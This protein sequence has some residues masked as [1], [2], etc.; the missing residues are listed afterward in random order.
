MSEQLG[1]RDARALLDRL[2]V[3]AITQPDALREFEAFLDRSPAPR[4]TFPMIDRR[5]G[6]ER[7][8]E[9]SAVLVDRRH[10]ARRAG[11]RDA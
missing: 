9:S 8:Q 6:S 7:R 11:D 5:R 10:I 1:E 4:L 3:L 2:Q